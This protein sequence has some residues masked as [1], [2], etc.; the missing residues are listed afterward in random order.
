MLP[1][2]TLQVNCWWGLQVAEISKPRH[3][4]THAIPRTIYEL[5]STDLSDRSRIGVPGLHNLLSSFLEEL[6]RSIPSR[7]GVG[8]SD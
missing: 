6:Q 4:K 8:I 7:M 1:W 2:Q 5:S 3:A